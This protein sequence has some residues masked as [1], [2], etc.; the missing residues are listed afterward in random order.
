MKR[1]FAMVLVVISV[2]AMAGVALAENRTIPGG[3]GVQVIADPDENRT[4]PGGPGVQ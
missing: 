3:P 4:I 1:S 2:L